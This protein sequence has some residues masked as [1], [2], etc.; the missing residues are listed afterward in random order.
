MIHAVNLTFSGNVLPNSLVFCSR[1]V[2]AVAIPRLQTDH[3]EEEDPQPHLTWQTRDLIST[4]DD[5]NMAF[6]AAD[7]K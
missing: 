1:L 4:G 6:N 3:M 7:H 2:V 5:V